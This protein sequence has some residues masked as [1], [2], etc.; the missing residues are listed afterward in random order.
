MATLLLIII[1]L[2][3]ISLGLPDSI[4]GV[5]WPLM[6]QEFNM[7]IDA[8]GY[9]S[10][11]A[12]LGTVVSSLLSGYLINR[13]KTKSVVLFSVFL[14]AI[15]I[16]GMSYS[17]SYYFVL[18]LAIPIGFGAG[19]IDTALNNFVALNYK[20]HHMN[21]LHSFWGLGASMGPYIL[22]LYLVN[23]NWRG[24]IRTISLIQFSFVLVLLISLPLW[25]KNYFNGKTQENDF[26][27]KI[28]VFKIKG[29][30]YAL[31]IFLI[32]VSL[33]YGVGLFGSSFLVSIRGFKVENAARLISFYYLGITIGRLISGFISIILSNVRLV[34]SGLIISAISIILIILNL[35]I[36]TTYIA[37]I[38]LGLGLAPIFPS[39]I[40]ET[41]K[42][43]GKENSGHVIGYQ[44]AFAYIGGSTIPPLIGLIAA[45]T[46]LAIFPYIL[47]ILIITIIILFILLVINTQKKV[48]QQ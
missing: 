14:T 29:V 16:F 36:T 33:E 26:S 31:F 35:H 20:A 48:G 47:L 32:Y 17:T 5:S 13:F 9:I 6:S 41:P 2:A 8:L 7:S 34:F 43:F 40:H 15:G 39:L 46:S 42:F 27:K 24:G 22:S 18:L 44:I 45:K 3:F 30:A 1:Y 4:I 28:K 23:D 21:W 10:L 12:T 25:H 38:L 19:S 37:F 11:V